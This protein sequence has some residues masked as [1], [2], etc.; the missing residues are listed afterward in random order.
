M[1]HRRSSTVMLRRCVLRVVVSSIGA[2]CTAL[3]KWGF[4]VFGSL[5]IALSVVI[6]PE[7]PEITA[8]PPVETR[9]L[10]RKRTEE[11]LL[12]CIRVDW[13]GG[14]ERWQCCRP[15]VA[16]VEQTRHLRRVPFQQRRALKQGTG[17]GAAL[18]EADDLSALDGDLA[19]ADAREADL[20]TPRRAHHRAVVPGGVHGE[21]SERID[22]RLTQPME[23]TP[24]VVLPQRVA[25]GEQHV[26]PQQLAWTHEHRPSPG[27]AAND[28]NVVLG[29]RRLG[30]AEHEGR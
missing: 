6:S 10:P 11:G 1:L 21:G 30:A 14:G 7:N 23:R 29:D 9:Q 26:D 28:R 13:K 24:D 22:P 4:K 18:G 12:E 27:A 8:T 25:G 16:E 2:A 19:G 20:T 15:F 17:A 5:W 3:A